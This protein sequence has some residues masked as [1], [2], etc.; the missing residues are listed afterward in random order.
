[1]AARDDSHLNSLLNNPLVYWSLPLVEC[2]LFG[3]AWH[4]YGTFNYIHTAIA[5]G[6]LGVIVVL[7]AA[8]PWLSNK[9]KAEEC[10]L[11]RRTNLLIGIFS[12]AVYELILFYFWSFCGFAVSS[13]QDAIAHA[14]FWQIL[15]VIL[16]STALLLGFLWFQLVRRAW[17]RF[18]I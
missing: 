13:N 9:S 17:T 16:F 12:I 7:S 10:L 18:F 3:L 5:L 11:K 8:G 1:M 15:S 6:L 14:W 2:I 4:R